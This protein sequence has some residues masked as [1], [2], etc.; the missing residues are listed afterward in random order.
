M[1]ISMFIN[2]YKYNGDGIDVTP[3]NPT[4]VKVT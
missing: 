1:I 3:R 4:R 2:K